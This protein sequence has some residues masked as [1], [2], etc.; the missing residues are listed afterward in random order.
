MSYQ[1]LA[2]RYRPA[3]FDEVVGQTTVIRTL[4]NA[5]EQDRI[6]HAFLLS[7]ARGVG[8]TTTARLLAKALNCARGE[9]PTAEPCGACDSCREI[10]EGHSLDVQEIDGASNNSVDQVREL[11]ESARY[12]PARDRFKI[13]IIDEV[14]MLSTGAFNAL[15]KTLE[16]PPPRVKFIFAT[17]EYHKI[18]ETILSRCQQYDFRMIPTRDLQAH[19]RAVADREGIRVGDAAL[20]QIA[21]AAEGS[22][23][24]GLSLFDQVLAFTGE[25]VKDDEVA[26]LLGLVDRELLHRASGAIVAGDSLAV[27]DLV[28][29]L[30]DYGADYRNFARELLL[31]LREILLVKLSPEDSPLQSAILPEERERLQARAAAF[32]EEDLLR[33]LDV[34]TRA[35]GELRVSPDPRVSLEL[36]LLK[37]VQFRKLLPFTELVAK[38]ERLAG[39][40]PAALPA[41]RPAARREAPAAPRRA[42]VAAPRRVAAGS[43]AA[44]A[45]P[46]TKAPPLEASPEP[47]PE[48]A[49]PADPTDAAGSLVAKML[50]GCVSRPSLAQ[51]LR[52][53]AARLDGKTLVLSVAPDFVAFANMHLGDYRDLAKKAAGRPVAV[54]IEAGAVAEEA[55]AEPSED[56]LRQQKLREE[57]EKEPAVQEALDLFD[58]RVVDV[59]EAKPP[60]EDA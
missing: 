23:R 3:T 25:E 45:S 44:S 5:I 52:R 37:L 7:G 9:G 47:G 1:V 34:L 51:P 56:E 50:E 20:G 17:T 55:P 12:N 29:S 31:H 41:G 35:E 2:L 30:A 33:G 21:R 46:A 19:L 40:A 38:V 53:A 24:D 11:R 8:K 4:R 14:H 16:E 49:G 32:S 59:R 54:E 13:W 42:A 43:A 6:G 26:G 39:G 28:E 18:P 57:A 48:A 22:V 36:A 58:G 27:F 60:R 10:A 15:L